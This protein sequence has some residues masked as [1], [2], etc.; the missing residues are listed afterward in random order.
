MFAALKPIRPDRH[1]LGIREEFPLRGL[2]VS[3]ATVAA[4]VMPI[5]WTGNAASLRQE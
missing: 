5:L 1:H 4:A 3:T 2:P